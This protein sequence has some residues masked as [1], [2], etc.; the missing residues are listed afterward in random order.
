MHAT[1]I[2]N[3]IHGSSWPLPPPPAASQGPEPVDRW[4]PESSPRRNGSAGEEPEKTILERLCMPF[5]LYRITV[6]HTSMPI[7]Y[8]SIHLTNGISEF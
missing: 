7:E 1:S 3:M 8:T 5:E 2:L 6:C 4:S